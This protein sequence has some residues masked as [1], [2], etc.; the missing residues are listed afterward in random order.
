MPPLSQALSPSPQ[1]FKCVTDCDLNRGVV[2]EDRIKFVPYIWY[3]PCSGHGPH[4]PL[5]KCLLSLS[6]RV[7]RQVQDGEPREVLRQ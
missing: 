7:P 4:L 6:L 5:I 1:Q 2:L 3:C